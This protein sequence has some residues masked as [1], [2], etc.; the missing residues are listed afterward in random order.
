MPCADTR[1]STPTA[2]QSG[3]CETLKEARDGMA[4]LDRRG[5]AVAGLYGYY[6]MVALD[7][8]VRRKGRERAQLVPE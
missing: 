4:A 2:S 3:V 5:L 6:D 7:T 1:T 8:E